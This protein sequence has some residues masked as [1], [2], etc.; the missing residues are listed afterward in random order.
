[1]KKATSLCRILCALTILTYFT[2]PATA[3]ILWSDDVEPADPATWTSYN[4]LVYIG[5]T[6]SGTVTVN[7]G[8]NIESG[9]GYIGYEPGSTGF[10]L[11]EGNGS[12]WIN[13]GVFY[14]GVEGSGTIEISNG[15]T[16]TSNRDSYIGCKTNSTGQVII[17]GNGSTWNQSYSLHVGLS[18][19]GT[20]E[21]TNGGKASCY[22]GQIGINPESTGSATVDGNDSIW[23]SSTS[24]HVGNHGS[25]T[26]QISNGG[27]VTA[28]ENTY[29]AFETN[30]TGSIHF[31]Q[32][33]LNTGGLIASFN[34]LTGTG[35]INTNGLVSDVDLVF[36]ATHSL[37]QSWVLN[38]NPGQNIA[39][40]LNI[41]GSGAMGAGHSGSGS[42]Q[43]SDGITVE[44]NYG[45][46]GNKASST[47]YVSVAGSGSTWTN[48]SSLFVGRYGSGTLE[49]TGGGTVSGNS[50]ISIGAGAGSTGLV[51]VDGNDSKLNANRHGITIGQFGSGTLSITNGGEVNSTT[52]R[53]GLTNDST[54]HVIVDG[55]GSKWTNSSS[56]YIVDSEDILEITN[57]GMVT[58]GGDIDSS[59][60]IH[61]NHGT[62]TT[63][64]LIAGSTNLTGI[65]TINTGGLVSD[66]DLVFDS[67]N[68]L[69]QT[70]TLND[71][72]GQYIVVNLNLNGTSSMGA[73]HSDK[74]TMQIS[75]G[76]IVESTLGYIGYK[77]GATGYVTVDGSGSAWNNSGNLYV[78]LSGNGTLGITNGG[79]VTNSIGFIGHGIRSTGYA[80]VSGNGSTW[81]NSSCLYVGERG[82]GTLEITDGGNVNSN[83]GFIGID[84]SSGYVYVNGIG[85]TW[86]NSNDL[87]IG[88]DS[89]AT[90]KVA[91][92]GK[93][94]SV[95]SIISDHTHSIGFV[96][97]DGNGSVWT[98]SGELCVGIYGSATLNITNGGLVTVAETLTVDKNLNGDSYIN[99]S[100]G[101]MLALMG[102]ADDSL[103]AFFDLILGTDAIQWWDESL[104]EDGDWA[105]LTTA[106]MGTDYTLEY[107]S[108]GELA[109]YTLLTVMADGPAV[110]EPSMI[111][112]LL[113]LMVMGLAGR[114]KRYSRR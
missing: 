50:S 111:A 10:V 63:G 19:N 81:N 87:W 26:L 89:N 20:F 59:G 16:V 114:G 102:D 49:I 86:T 41:N 77:R 71:N 107:L 45:Y 44:S 113:T 11:I 14:V 67:T 33:T 66:V 4:T 106:T 9:R 3:S 34:D 99:M 78:G 54:G 7:G 2:P 101:G 80:T 52:G 105:S 94:S 23:S 82:N 17:D 74:G 29:V 69:S 100:N 18:G 91:N 68:S 53:I 56:F 28:S 24:L 65:G 43:I 93:V 6:A 60:I 46:I 103:D 22:E 58:N 47:G 110:P 98:N 104:G 76:V 96:S 42:M 51:I 31:D 40:N 62:L 109:G 108:D 27:V 57:G 36:D 112:M 32:G 90:L 37:N 97:I 15:G 8:D 30:S 35:T 85:S 72:F 88:C 39:I 70:L 79:K 61:L 83:Y 38:E 92:G 48:S 12:K 1:M 95:S 5:K 21:I 25:G 64:G 84:T 75:D 73:G 55:N 13:S